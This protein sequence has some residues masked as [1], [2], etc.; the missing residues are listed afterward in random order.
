MT[1]RTIVVEGYKKMLIKDILPYIRK[2]GSDQT[3]SWFVSYNF[4][5]G[6]E[7]ISSS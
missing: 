3:L 4:S 7:A 2:Y 6:H 1:S 5:R